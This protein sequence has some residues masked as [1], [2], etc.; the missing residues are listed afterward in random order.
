MNNCEECA[1]YWKNPA[2]G[3]LEP[4]IM[5]AMGS[6]DGDQASDETATVTPAHEES[7]TQQNT[8]DDT[9]INLIVQRYTQTGQMP[10]M[11]K[12]PMF[13]DFTNVPTFVQ[14]LDMIKEGEAAFMTLPAR[15]RAEFDNDPAEWLDAVQEA[16]EAGNK[17]EL[18]RLGI[19]VAPEP[20]PQTPE[21]G[22][23]T[24]D[25]PVSGPIDN[26]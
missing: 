9:D 24:T 13:G 25:K 22:S 5:R 1:M 20:T 17:G 19:Y 15:V 11:N 16:G 2:T 7:L 6:Y 21:G 3:E 14:A 18:K 8:Q 4:L 10:V 12:P 26:K 23:K